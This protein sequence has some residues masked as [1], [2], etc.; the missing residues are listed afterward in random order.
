MF[1]SVFLTLVGLTCNALR[2]VIC[3]SAIG[4]TDQGS[5]VNINVV[6]KPNFHFRQLTDSIC[7]PFQ[8]QCLWCLKTFKT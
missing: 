8:K 1:A 3:A 4:L 5:L 7:E 6:V 2:L